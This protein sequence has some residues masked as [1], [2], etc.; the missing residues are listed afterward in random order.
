MPQQSP[1]QIYV[2]GPQYNPYGYM[3]QP[4]Q[5]IYQPQ[6]QQMQQPQY[7]MYGQ[8]SYGQ[9]IQ[10]GYYGPQMQQQQQ[11]DYGP[12]EQAQGT[13]EEAVVVTPKN[14]GR[15]AATKPWKKKIPMKSIHGAQGVTVALLDVTL[16]VCL[17]ILTLPTP[18]NCCMSNWNAY[19][20]PF[21]KLT[22]VFPPL[23]YLVLAH[24]YHLFR[25]TRA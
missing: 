18:I 3:Q 6:Q 25:R 19:C 7:P 2:P 5:P 17:S 11:P 10:T 14:E 1:R 22:C 16:S 21:F 4:Q 15:D 24:L 8:Q 13:T 12:P 20:D 9:P 23:F